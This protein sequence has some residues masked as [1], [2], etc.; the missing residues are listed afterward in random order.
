MFPTGLAH[1]S[2]AKTFHIVLHEHKNIC[3]LLPLI[4]QPSHNCPYFN[5]KMSENFWRKGR[6]N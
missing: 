2:C 5:K 6:Q 1:T 4:V 3:T